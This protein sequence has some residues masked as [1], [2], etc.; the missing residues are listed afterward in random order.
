[1]CLRKTRF[2]ANDGR[3]RITKFFSVYCRTAGNDL[4]YVPLLRHQENR[5][6]EGLDLFQLY[7]INREFGINYI[8]RH[9]P[10]L[11]AGNIPQIV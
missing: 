8:Y 5:G 1:M 9:S 11:A 10:R 3:L 4:L 2:F 6:H 7:S